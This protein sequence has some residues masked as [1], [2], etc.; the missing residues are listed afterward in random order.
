MIY[1]PQGISTPSDLTT[2]TAVIDAHH[3]F[4]FQH[5]RTGV[6][7][8]PWWTDGGGTVGLPANWL[9]GFPMLVTRAITIDRL[10]IEVTI[11]GA[12][13]TKARLGI[14]NN[15]ANL[16]PGT[17]V[18]DGGEVAVDGIAVVAATIAQSLN[19][20]IYCLAIVTDGTPTVRF[21]GLSMSPI[22]ANPATL[23]TIYGRWR[24]AQAYGALPDPFT[25]GAVVGTSDAC[26]FIREA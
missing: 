15:G 25:A 12:G 20:G 18:I 3:A 1:P 16:Y 21:H 6:Y 23:T 19:P 9:H 8:M 14:Y 2:H 4:P 10:A 11:A 17:L 26:I 24:V 13:G 5:M 7:Y 22:G